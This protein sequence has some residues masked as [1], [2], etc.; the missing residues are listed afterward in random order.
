M[1]GGA[2]VE[3][4]W[5]P[6]H[7]CHKLSEGCLHC[8]VYRTDAKHGKDS[9]V[10]AKTQNFRLP[11]QKARDGSYKIPHGS[12][13]YTCFTSDFFVEDADEWRPEAWRMMRQ[14]SDLHFLFITKRIERFEVGL[15]EDWGNGYQNVT[16]CCTAE[17]QKRADYR[18]PLYL[19]KPIRHKIIICEPLLEQ[20]DLKAYLTSAIE[21]VI[22][23]GESGNDARICDYAWI[24]SLRSQCMKQGVGFHFKQTGARFRKDGKEYRVPRKYQHIQ[25]A[26]AAID[27]RPK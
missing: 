21:E 7:G 23:G 27:Y 17:N 22:A 19:A 12:L 11:I 4:T 10:V 6:W 16:I 26:K 3:Y 2:L 13:V 15:P 8:Y 18:L 9:F 5:N 14:R 20:I 1:N 25:A 24:L